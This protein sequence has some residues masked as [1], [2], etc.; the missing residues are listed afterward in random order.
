M[1]EAHT[2]AAARKGRRDRWVTARWRIA[3]V[4]LALIVA[5]IGV[6]LIPTDR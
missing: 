2:I 5:I 3:G 6:G 1:T 4:L